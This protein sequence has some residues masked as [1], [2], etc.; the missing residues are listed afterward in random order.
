[1]NIDKFFPKPSMSPK[2]AIRSFQRGV[3]KV[4]ERDFFEFF[5]VLTSYSKFM[6]IQPLRNHN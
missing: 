3:F 1:M 6:V 5:R 2:E 4:N